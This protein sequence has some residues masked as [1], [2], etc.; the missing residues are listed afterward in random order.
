MRLMNSVPLSLSSGPKYGTG[1]RPA[2]VGARRR[3]S[4][5]ACRAVR[6]K[7]P[8]RWPHRPCSACT[9]TGR[10]RSSRRKATALVTSLGSF[11]SRSC[12]RTASGAVTTR[13][14]NSLAAWVRALSADWRATRNV[15]TISLGPSPVLGWA[16]AVPASTARAAAS[17][18]TE[19]D[20]PRRRRVRRS[21]RSTSITEILR[22]RSQRASPAP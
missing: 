1:G 15:R 4:L 18:S 17:A 9:G 7:R 13:A 11:S 22:A 16:V 3:P 2:A 6:R 19:S 8:S 12:A 5:H 21:G 10:R 14:C 20:L